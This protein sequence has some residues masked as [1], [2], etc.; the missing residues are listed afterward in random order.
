MKVLV[1]KKFQDKVERP[2]T[3]I[4]FSF[5]KMIS[6]LEGLN[7]A[8][9]EKSGNVQR[10]RGVSEEIYVIRVDSFRVFFTRQKDKLVLLDAELV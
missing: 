9:L 7:P 5:E 8:G 10:V 3:L 2:E 1:S 6:T 4:R